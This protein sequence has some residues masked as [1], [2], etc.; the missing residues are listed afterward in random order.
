MIEELN[1]K[2]G[3]RM[4]DQEEIKH[5]VFHHFKDIYMDKEETDPLARVDILSGIPSLITE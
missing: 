1:D 5:H 3:K 4:V 2:D